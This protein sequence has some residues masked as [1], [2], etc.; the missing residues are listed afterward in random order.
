MKTYAVLSEIKYSIIRAIAEKVIDLNRKLPP[1]ERIINLTMGQNYI[2]DPTLVI[3]HIGKLYSQKIEPLLYAP[4]LGTF[5]A[6]EAVAKRFYKLWYNVELEHDEVM[7]T[8]GAM[9]A[10]RN[11]MGAVVRDGDIVVIDPLTFIYVLD[12]LKILGRKYEIFVLETSD[13]KY[14]MPKPDEVIEKLQELSR[15]YTDK[16]IVYYTQLGFNPIGVFRSGKDL[17]KIVEFIDDSKNVFLIN[18]IVYH[19]I[20]FDG[21]EMPLASYMSDE[22]RN[23]V[24]C[25]SLSKPFSLMGLRV[26][27][28]ITRDKEIFQAAAKVQQ[29][30]IVSPNVLAC[31]VWRI[32]GDPE[33]FPELR[34]GIEKLNTQLRKNYEAISSF[35]RR[36]NIE[37][38]S[39][40]QGTLYAFIRVPSENS[41][42]FVD[43]LI[44][45]AR[46]AIVP[47]TA[48][49][50][51]PSIGY[52]YAR[53]T[54]SFPEEL[55]SRAIQRMESFLSG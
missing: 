54:I 8:D 19:L 13:K 7:I 26:G 31:E 25:D 27:A 42:E 35:C 16:N 33:R 18:D 10:I 28:M 29:Y 12:T 38:I 11:A 20:R 6:R 15:K 21:L 43:E 40:G 45:K 32:A 39:P 5:E 9:G 55:I 36:A 48:F 30:T 51:K 37:M 23:I 1:E 52:R 17:R 3:K 14:Y 41:E 2:G 46:V 24:D 44:E 4:S 53:I 22:G 49:E 50:V 47:G 34:G